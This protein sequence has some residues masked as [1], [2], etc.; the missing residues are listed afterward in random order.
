MA[1]MTVSA[2]NRTDFGKGAS[3]RMRRQGMVPGIV[4]G[5]SADNIPVAV[6][7]KDLFR[8][9][10]SQAGRNTILNLDIEGTSS[11]SVIL[12]DWQIDPVDESILHADFHRI[13]MDRTLRVT[14]PVVI[15][16]TAYGVKTEGGLLEVVTRELDVECLPSDIPNE[17]E[18]DVTDLAMNRSIRVGELTSIDNVEVLADREQIV[19]HVVAMKEEVEEVAEDEDV[20]ALAEA[21]DGESPEPEVAAKGKVDE[22]DGQ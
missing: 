4:Y 22:G 12:K 8:L 7:P 2:T 16:G 10:R 9:L 18:C 11:D 13:A 6:N 20:E 5:G 21:S 19:V 14:V 1:E 3:K 15:H 17:F